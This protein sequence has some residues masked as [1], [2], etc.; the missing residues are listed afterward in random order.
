MSGESIYN[1][2]KEVPPPPSKPEMYRSMI[3]P[4]RPLAATTFS[5][6]AKKKPVGVIGRV[7]KDTVKPN[8]FL[9]AHDKTGDLGTMA[10]TLSA[11]TYEEPLQRRSKSAPRKPA[12]PKRDE[13]PVLGLSSGRNFVVS[14]AVEAILAPIRARVRKPDSDWLRKPGY[15][16]TP[17]YLVEMR[18]AIDQEKEFL[19]E[20]LRQQESEEKARAPGMRELTQEER[21]E[22]IVALK[23]KWD[24]VNKSYQRITFKNISADTATAFLID[25]KEN[26]ER[27]LAQVEKDIQR[28]SVKAAIYVVDN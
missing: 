22:L 16:K 12:V 7:V 14:N 3:S 25:M 28:L 8:Q 5:E 26:C 9:R 4:T 13:M 10:K 19:D 2:I 11:G 18:K 20:L 17:D 21:H 23:T 15:G 24:E 1:F 27:T 6:T